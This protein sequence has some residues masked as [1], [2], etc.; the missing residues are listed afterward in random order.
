[1]LQLMPN[2]RLAILRNLIRRARLAAYR[3]TRYLTLSQRF[4]LVAAMVVALAMV[5]LGS[6]IGL[7]LQS[8]I[9]KGIV[10]SAA[11]SIDS[12][13]SHQF[14]A[15]GP[16]RL[17]TEEDR[18]K[19]DKVFE[20]GNDADST[21]LLQIQI[22]NLDGSILYDSFGGLSDDVRPEVFMAAAQQGTVTSSVRNLPLAPVGP[23]EE[24]SI[25][26]LR[27]FT[28]LHRPV[29]GEIFAVAALY[30]SAKALHEIQFRAQLDVW[31]LVGLI[32][33]GVIGVLF[34]L[35]G[36]EPRCLTKIVRGEPHAAR[37]IRT[38]APGRQLCQ[39]E[40]PGSGR[41]GHPRRT[42]PAAD[43]DY[44]AADAG[45]G[46]GRQEKGAAATRPDRD[47]PVGHR[48]NGGIAQR[49]GRPGAA[50]TRRAEHRERYPARDFQT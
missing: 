45:Q 21:R 12:L 15:L 50:R 10:T 48:R 44:L 7:Y 9:T 41:L 16:E 35:V 42:D 24:H 34:V 49:L 26:V 38:A 2:R 11:A 3:L 36:K 19:L 28:P 33:L 1:M 32:G 43:P 31:V 18:A 5:V 47:Y 27:I 14:D 4:L 29:T 20:I 37:G 46:R 40:P 6:W 25:A 8:S 39:R 30:Y 22:R 17:L 13:I 23:L